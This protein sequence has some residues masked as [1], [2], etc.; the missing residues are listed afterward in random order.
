MA[1]VVA[2]EPSFDFRSGEYVSLYKSSHA[3]A[4]QCPHWLAGI[5]DIVM[6]SIGAESIT[7]TARLESERLALV[8]PLMRR[9]L[10]G[11]HLVEFAGADLCDYQNAIYSVTDVNLLLADTT[12]P[13]RVSACLSPC[14][15]IRVSKLQDHDAVLRALFPDARRGVMRVAT[16]PSA[17]ETDWRRWRYNNIDHDFQRYLDRKRRRLG[18]VGKIKFLLVEDRQEIVRVFEH[19]RRF[20]ADRFKELGAHDVTAED[21]IFLF[22]QKSAID[23][24]MHGFSSTYCLYLDDQPIAVLFGLRDNQ[25]FWLVLSASDTKR[26]RNYSPGLLAIEDAIRECI[27]MGLSI[28]DFTVGDHSYKL[29]FGGKK[30]PLF[31]WHIPRTARGYFGTAVLEGVRE[32]KRTLKPWLKKDGHWGSPQGPPRLIDRCIGSLRK[33]SR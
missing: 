29:Q 6:P 20:R 13:G 31:E 24:A 14:D 7:I 30:S 23:G 19:V 11:M 21:S 18:R 16:Y 25:K 22:Y 32:T 2:N 9:R 8:L 33:L 12:L 10:F 28:F 5:H 1:L 26:Y 27:H 15:L 3:A 4:F 17:L